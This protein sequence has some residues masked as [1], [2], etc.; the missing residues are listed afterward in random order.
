[1]DG[2]RGPTSSSS[3]TAS[4][5]GGGGARATPSCSPTSKDV[6]RELPERLVV[7]TGAYGRMRPAPAAL[8]ALEKRG[9]AVEL[10]PTAEAVRRYAEL[11]RAARPPRSTSPAEDQ[12]SP[13]Q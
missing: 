4:F 6:L 5:A 13:A 11:D 2:R 10:L 8:A 1:M 9:V 12:G 3:P 7:G